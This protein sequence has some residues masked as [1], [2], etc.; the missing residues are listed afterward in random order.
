MD[1]C[2]QDEN[3]R[4]HRP[5][6][7]SFPSPQPPERVSGSI[8]TPSTVRVYVT[9]TRPI[10][11]ASRASHISFVAELFGSFPGGD[12][13]NGLFHLVFKVFITNS[14]Q[15]C[16][17]FDTLGH[18]G[19]S[20]NVISWMTPF[21]PPTCSRVKWFIYGPASPGVALAGRWGPSP[22]P[23]AD[24]ADP[25]QPSIPAGR[26]GHENHVWDEDQSLGGWP[27]PG[28]GFA[29]AVVPETR[30]GPRLPAPTCSPSP[31]V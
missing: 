20:I 18:A 11:F 31:S 21:P 9:V 7:A 6:Q 29:C 28:L 2:V 30:S 19:P 22:P 25:S 16:K 8:L 4:L 24:G 13:S 23:R 26:T 27:C 14:S 5:A 12:V 10:L 3:M 17:S 15:L 1:C